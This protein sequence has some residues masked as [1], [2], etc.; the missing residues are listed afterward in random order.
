MEEK[1]FDPRKLAKLNGPARL[2]YLD[3]AIW[4]TVHLFHMTKEV[5]NGFMG[6]NVVVV[7]PPGREG[8]RP[9][10]RQE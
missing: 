7:Y 8:R 6:E 4:K 3:P 9:G 2:A 5:T 10:A 1:K